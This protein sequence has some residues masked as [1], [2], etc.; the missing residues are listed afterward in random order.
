MTR[1]ITIVAL[2]CVLVVGAAAAAILGRDSVPAAQF[3]SRFDV[4]AAPEAK[5][6]VSN[7]EGKKDKLAVVALATAAFGRRSRPRS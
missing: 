4:A 2:T 6:P 5:G 7:K 1:A 3:G